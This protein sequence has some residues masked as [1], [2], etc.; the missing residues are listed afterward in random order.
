MALDEHM[1]ADLVEDALK[2]AITLRGKLPETG[3]F[4][5]DRGTQY[6]PKQDRRTRRRKRPHAVDGI[7]RHLLG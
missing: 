4:H 2:M 1:R 7:H 6:P 3:V 5:T